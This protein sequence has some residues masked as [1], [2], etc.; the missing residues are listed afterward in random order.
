VLFLLHGLFLEKA[1]RFSLSLMQDGAFDVVIVGGGLGGL[2]CAVMLAKE[3][4]KVCVLEKNRQIGGC[5]QSFAFRKTV[6]DACVHYMGGLGEGHSLHQIFRYAGI[7]PGLRLQALREDGFD[8]IFFKEETQA[9]PLASHAQFVDRLLPIFPKEKAALQGY[10]AALRNAITSFPLYHLG[11]GGAEEK[12][13]MMGTPLME[14][15]QRLTRD[16]R[17]QKVLLGNNMLYAGAEGLTPFYVHALTTDSY[18]HSAHKVLP[19]T[20]QIAKLLGRQ[21]RALGGLVH[22]H[23]QVAR[24]HEAGGKIAFAEAKDGVRFYGT[25]FISAIHPV[26]LFSLLDGAGLRPAFQQRVRSLPQTPAALMVNLVL[27]PG[28]LRYEASNIYWHPSGEVLAKPTRAGL[29]WPD[30]Q[31]IYFGEDDARPGFAAS[32]TILAYA[33]EE[34]FRP[35]RDSKNI[36]GTH[37]RRDDGY[38]AFKEAQAEALLTKTFTRFPELKTATQAL[39]VA[40]PLSFRDYMG[41]PSGSLYGALKDASRPAQNML[42]VR[43]KVSNLL[44]T[45]QH[46]NMHGVMG[47]SISAVATCAEL[48]GFDYL[49]RR[50]REA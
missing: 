16:E 26:A 15:L 8:R 39:S 13:A 24:L 3:G 25:Q 46:L 48:L 20:S 18:L 4:Q 23:E 49:L 5:L 40:T 34:D 32:A 42:P 31:A 30:T 29:Q 33:Q 45:G 14:P 1:R 12:M 10:L 27:R 50:I 36:T 37:H 6:F 28:A 21:L 43:T 9:Y 38:E 22:R 11:Q 17:L 35:W 41:A 44:L 19:A 47:V 2:L 7:L